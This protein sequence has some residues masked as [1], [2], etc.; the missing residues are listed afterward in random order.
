[1]P[2]HI[3]LD[4]KWLLLL[5]KVQKQ[6]AKCLFSS[7]EKYRSWRF[8]KCLPINVDRG[9]PIRFRVLKSVVATEEMI[10]KTSLIGG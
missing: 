7:V 5:L 8:Q 9:M 2:K 3:L 6:L 1:M 4:L 10:I